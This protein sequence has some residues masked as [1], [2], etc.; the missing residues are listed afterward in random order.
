M[1]LPDTLELGLSIPG[2]PE[3][4]PIVR[5]FAGRVLDL[6]DLPAAR[7]DDLAA[8]VVSAVTLVETALEAEGDAAVPIEI[9]ATIARDRIEFRILEH[10]VPLGGADVAAPGRDIGDR[11]RP[12]RVFDRMHWVQ[13]GR[14]G[15]ELHLVAHRDDAAIRVLDSAEHRLEDDHDATAHADLDPSARTGEYRIRPYRTEDGLDIARRIYEA[16]GRSYPNPDLYVPERVDRLNREGRLRSIVCESPAGEVVG[17]YALERPDLE[18]IGEAG[19]AV[20]DHRHRGHGLMK[21]M[22]SAVE[23]AGADLGLLGIWSQPTARHPIS[24]RM[25]LGFGSSPCALCLGTTPANA[26]LRGGV[27][28]QVEDAARP[29]RHSCFLYWHPLREEPPLVAHVPESLAPI[30]ERLYAARGRAV[31][32]ETAPATPADGHGSLRTRF[33]ATRRT[34]WIGVDRVTRG[35]ADA[36]PAAI[37]A[38]TSS[39]GAETIFVDL[40]IDDPGTVGL[41]QSLLATGLRPAGVGPRFRRVEDERRG[42]DV[43]RLQANPGPV[44]FDGLVIEGELGRALAEIVLAATD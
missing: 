26:S 4:A 8:A 1:P 44:D 3:L 23:A 21:P 6:A 17:H 42:E 9:G 2:L 29:A 12:G 36:L 37:E 24:Q 27:Q 5:E 38:M 18:S 43:L 22:R 15:S 25:N 40:P 14:E 32:I 33:D 34:A 16:Y 19:Q 10:G 7:R 11:I 13:R 41:A 30:L 20:I 28:G 31:S 35:S 39:A